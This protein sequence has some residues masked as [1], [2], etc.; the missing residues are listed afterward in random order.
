VIRNAG[1]GG[2]TDAPQVGV[3]A[4]FSG[5]GVWKAS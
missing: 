5:G 2:R 3:V 4:K 1:V